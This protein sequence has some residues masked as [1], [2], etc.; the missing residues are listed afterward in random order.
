[1]VLFQRDEKTLRWLQC[2]IFKGFFGKRFVLARDFFYKLNKK[3]SVDRVDRARS[4][5]YVGYM[6]HTEMSGL[7]YRVFVKRI[8]AHDECNATHCCAA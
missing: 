3:V 5:V 6:L 4:M 8:R 7:I 1:M 2:A